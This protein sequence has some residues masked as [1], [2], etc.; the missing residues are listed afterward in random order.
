MP[1]H[2]IHIASVD[3]WEAG[4]GAPEVRLSAALLSQG[5]RRFAAI[6]RPGAPS[7]PWLLAVGGETAGFRGRAPLPGPGL[8]SQ[9]PGTSVYSPIYPLTSPAASSAA[10][11]RRRRSA[12]VGPAIS[13]VTIT[14][15]HL[16]CQYLWWVA[17]R[18]NWRQSGNTTGAPCKRK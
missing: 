12:T 7:V 16:K 9:T 8:V 1:P 6:L 5:G 13:Q 18:H 10:R 14:S 3:G 17:F 11:G 15:K 4:C 2:F